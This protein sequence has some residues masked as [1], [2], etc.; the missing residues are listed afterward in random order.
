MTKPKPP[1]ITN[2]NDARELK[3]VGLPPN[4]PLV[5]KEFSREYSEHWIDLMNAHAK[6]MIAVREFSDGARIGSPG[7]WRLVKRRLDS[8]HKAM[9][10]CD[11]FIG[12]L[13][14]NIKS[15]QDRHECALL[16]F[17]IADRA[18]PFVE[19]WD[20]AIEVVDAGTPLTIKPG[21][22]PIWND[23]DPT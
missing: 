20:E 8:L 12:K 1:T 21:D 14:S 10:R 13:S 3:S 9:E 19:F 7:K 11:N 22:V 2:L 18:L 15:E 5:R 17:F 4:L 23:P 16:S 6:F